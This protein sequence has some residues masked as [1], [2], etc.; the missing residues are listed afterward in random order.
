[1]G[2]IKEGWAS[3]L[4]F[5]GTDVCTYMLV[6]LIGINIPDHQFQSHRETQPTLVLC[7]S[8]LR[9]APCFIETRREPLT[10]VSHRWRETAARRWSVTPVRIHGRLTQHGRKCT[11][12]F[13]FFS[14]PPLNDGRQRSADGR[15]RRPNQPRISSKSHLAD[16]DS[17]PS[18]RPRW[19]QEGSSDS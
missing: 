18:P 17:L 19:V 5:F 13:S 15:K 16:R 3:R 7:P 2:S 14:P 11:L 10:M 4:I 1:M 6:D 8:F 9:Y 12:F